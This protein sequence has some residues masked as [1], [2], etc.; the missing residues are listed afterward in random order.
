[1]LHEPTFEK[2][3]TMR[4]AAMAAA[5]QQQQGDANAAELGFDDRCTLLVEAEHIARD[6]RR[7]SRL[8]KQAQLRISDACVEDIEAG[9]ARGFDKATGVSS[10]PSAGS[11]STSTC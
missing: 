8:R 10:R 4:L 11:A 9:G 7:L 2:L 6:N 1:M 3:Y 5:W